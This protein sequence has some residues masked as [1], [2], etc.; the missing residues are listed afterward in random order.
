MFGKQTRQR[1]DIAP[2]G[3]MIA[4]QPMLQIVWFRLPKAFLQIVH[5]ASSPS[6]GPMD[7][8]DS[9]ELF[10]GKRAF[11]SAVLWRGRVGVAIDIA[12]AQTTTQQEMGGT[13]ATQTFKAA[14][15]H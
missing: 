10:A 6:F 9:L 2:S 8:I 11:T 7:P 13:A 14:S 15:I 12:D 4:R 1:R 3:Q 5:M